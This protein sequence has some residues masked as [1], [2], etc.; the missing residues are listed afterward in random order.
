MLIGNVVC[1][2]DFE[3]RLM[4]SDRVFVVGFYFMVNIW[5]LYGLFVLLFF[6]FVVIMVE[7]MLFFFKYIKIMFI[8][9]YFLNVID[10]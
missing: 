6:F 5:E 10:Y 2:W 7:K 1:V 4:N 3:F 8:V 9:S